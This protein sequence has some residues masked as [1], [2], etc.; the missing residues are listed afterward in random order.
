MEMSKLIDI[1]GIGEVYAGK[2]VA[3]GIKTPRA[4]LEMGSTTSGRKSIADKLA[5]SEIKILEWVN[6]LDLFRVKG[7][8]GQYAD[9]LEA[10]GVD[11]V[12]ELAQRNPENLYQKLSMV[13]IEKNLVR[14]LPTLK[15][16]EGWV[17]HAK[18]L[19]RVITY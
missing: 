8:A 3:A 13:N 12:V 19:P 7:V 2:L 11:T 17:Q 15:Q 1:E 5:I 9:L 4:L 6:H 18:T 10:A 14:K 16:V